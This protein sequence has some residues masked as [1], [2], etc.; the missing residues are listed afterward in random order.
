MRKI[1]ALTFVV[2]GI[3]GLSACT[4][5]PPAQTQTPLTSSVV[6]QPEQ[7]VTVKVNEVPQEVVT[8][9]S[10]AGTTSTV[11]TV[12]PPV[13][14]SETVTTT[15]DTPLID[16]WQTSPECVKATSAPFYHPSILKK[17]KLGSNEVV[18]GHPTGGCFNMDLPDR[19]R[20]EFVRIE[21]GREFVYD[22]NTGKVLRLA[23]CNNSVHGFT[24]FSTQPTLGLKGLP[25]SVTVDITNQFRD[26]VVQRVDKP[27]APATTTV[28][29]NTGWWIAGAIIVVLVGGA[30]THCYGLCPAH[31][32]VGPGGNTGGAFI[33][34]GGLGITW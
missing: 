22:K 19:V 10:P 26:G 6:S 29:N 28:S 13:A 4:S 30:V 32:G 31:K 14:V 8:T 3:V 1:T 15:S 9:T 11:T 21:Q 7:R 23:E 33:K 27:S 17:Q 5:V 34:T 20:N 16:H 18:R 12:I 2:L 24:P 25:T